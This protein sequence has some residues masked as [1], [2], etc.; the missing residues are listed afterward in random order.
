MPMHFQG[1]KFLPEKVSERE[2]QQ[3]NPLH[4]S[5]WQIFQHNFYIENP[6]LYLFTQFYIPTLL[7]R[8]VKDPQYTA[9]SILSNS[10]P[11]FHF[12]ATVCAV[13]VT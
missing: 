5:L 8:F 13:K 2:E 11:L 10:G 7:W 9:T 3:N 6:K 1:F 4:L 12:F